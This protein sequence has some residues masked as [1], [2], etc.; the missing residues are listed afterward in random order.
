MR[1]AL[2]VA[3]AAVM[4]AA[5]GGDGSRAQFPAEWEVTGVPVDPQ[6]LAAI[7]RV[8]RERAPCDMPVGGDGYLA[9]VPT[10]QECKD[11]DARG[12]A[13]WRGEEA[14][15]WVTVQKDPDIT[16]RVTIH[17]LGHIAWEV[18]GGASY[19][20]DTHAH[21]PDFDAWVTWTNMAAGPA[22]AGMQPLTPPEPLP[23]VCM[24]YG[25]TVVCYNPNRA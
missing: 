23:E 1:T 2:A 4:L 18:C 9:Y 11:V 10:I 5:C 13:G 6:T 8:V 20:W 24:P 15:V 22:L 3:V 25:D 12:C 17:E 19:D 16:L 7:I 14:S 21:T